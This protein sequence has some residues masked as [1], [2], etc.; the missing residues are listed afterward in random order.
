MHASEDMS[1]P[2]EEV[3]N[4]SMRRALRTLN[5]SLVHYSV[6]L[7]LCLSMAQHSFGEGRDDGAQATTA[8]ATRS[9]TVADSI[10]MTHILDPTERT[11]GLRP[12]FSPDGGKFLVV[13]E[14]GLLDANARE[15]SLLVYNMK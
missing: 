4:A 7:G 5:M 2:T 11:N 9:F 1:K 3:S 6:A 13:K 14:K 10:E 12:S 15:Y 8:Q